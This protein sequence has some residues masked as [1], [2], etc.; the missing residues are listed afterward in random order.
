LTLAIPGLTRLQA[1]FSGVLA[2]E[3]CRFSP[4]WEIAGITP[5]ALGRVRS[6]LLKHEG[7][8]LSRRPTRHFNV[9][10]E[11]EQAMRSFSVR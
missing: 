4:F 5:K 3:K 6:V 10:A 11:Y 7:E 1:L 2:A 8:L 9:S